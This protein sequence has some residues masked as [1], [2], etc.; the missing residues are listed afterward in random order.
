MLVN[1]SHCWLLGLEQYLAV[2]SSLCLSIAVS[3]VIS[4][5]LIWSL[6]VLSCLEH[7]LLAVSSS[8]NPLDLLGLEQ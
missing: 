3:Q 7:Y 6:E 2:N 8:T 1:S 5:N 4:I